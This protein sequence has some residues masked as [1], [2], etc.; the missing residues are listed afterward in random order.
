MMRDRGWIGQART[1]AR[2]MCGLTILLV[3]GC[4]EE[5][6]PIPAMPNIPVKDPS[7]AQNTEVAGTWMITCAP[8]SAGCHDFMI[9]FAEGGDIVDF[10]IGGLDGP[11]KG[12]GAIHGQTLHFVV[13]GMVEFDGTLDAAGESAT[14]KV[15]GYGADGTPMTADAQAVR[16]NPLCRSYTGKRPRNC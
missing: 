2:V 5:R 3:I 15:T 8:D 11:A 7:T 6:A 1:V 16:G 10:E 13:K 9:D 4:A 14:G 12:M